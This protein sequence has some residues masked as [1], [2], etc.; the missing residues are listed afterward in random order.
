VRS[1]ALNYNIELTAE[2]LSSGFIPGVRR[3]MYVTTPYVTV[4]DVYNQAPAT[5]ER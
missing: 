3:F 2:P 4:G 1:E 5:T